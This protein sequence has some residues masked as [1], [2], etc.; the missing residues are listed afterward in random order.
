MPLNPKLAAWYDVDKIKGAF[1]VLTGFFGALWQ[2]VKDIFMSI[3][4]PIFER[5]SAFIST[6]QGVGH[7]TLAVPAAPVAAPQV[8]PPTAAG[9]DGGGSATEH[10]NHAAVDLTVKAAPG[11]AVAVANRAKHARVR[12]HQTPSGANAH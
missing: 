10:T 1:S 3:M 12:V 7:Q 5:I 4:G 2:G 9:R 6:V 11:T 8:V